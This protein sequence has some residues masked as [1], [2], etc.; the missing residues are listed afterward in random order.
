MACTSYLYR[1]FPGLLLSCGVACFAALLEQVEHT[2]TGKAWVDGLVLAILAGTA[3]RTF[4]SP[5]IR[6]EAGIQFSAHRLLE[7]AVAMMGA[8]ISTT[9]V[10]KA[11]PTLVPAVVALVVVAVAAGILIGRI[12]GLPPKMAILIACGNAICGNSAIAAVAP[13]IDAE[14]DD[15]ATAVAFTAV[16]GIAVVLLLPCIAEGLHLTQAAGGTLAGLTVYA[17]PQVVAAAGPLGPM[18]VQAGTLVKLLRVLMLGPVVACFSL[19]QACRTQQGHGTARCFRLTAFLP[20][21]ILVFMG[22]MGARSLGL[23][24]DAVLASAHAASR[25]LTL[26]AMA[27]LGLGVDLRSVLA[28]GPRVVAVVTLSLCFLGVTALLILRLAGLT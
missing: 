3:L 11:G 26:V 16:L 13:V 1:Y 28:A 5:S 17:V 7:A 12:F 19:V 25:T 21:F 9:L 10:L 14:S 27:G 18:A 20:P 6:F 15:T 22:L 24:P 4:W 8:A 23:I 2:M